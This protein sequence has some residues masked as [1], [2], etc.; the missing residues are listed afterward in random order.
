D[1]LAQ[2]NAEIYSAAGDHVKA[3]ETYRRLLAE[4]KLDLNYYQ[5]LI[6]A[7]NDAK[8]Y[9][10]SIKVVKQA[11][12]QFGKSDPEAVR[13]MKGMVYY[14]KKDYKNAEKAF[15]DLV[16]RTNGKSDDAY[17]FLGSV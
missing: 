5:Y 6:D 11:E 2:L 17:Y 13:L 10:E 1:K 7:L 15:K 4:N 12:E 9:E 16:T 14:K 3:I 8:K